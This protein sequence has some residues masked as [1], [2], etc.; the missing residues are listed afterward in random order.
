V[1]K[2]TARRTGVNSLS[3]QRN[4]QLPPVHRC[5]SVRLV[6]A[7]AVPYILT[8]FKLPRLSARPR[9]Q[10]LS[11]DHDAFSE[12]HAK[13]GDELF[14]LPLVPLVAPFEAELAAVAADFL[15][16]F[17][18]PGVYRWVPGVDGVEIGFHDPSKRID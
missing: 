1:G 13:P 15:Q 4:Y 3:R 6:V 2:A 18:D 8:L 11:L 14:D 10:A 17:R 9:G 12:F 16:D 7:R 5:A